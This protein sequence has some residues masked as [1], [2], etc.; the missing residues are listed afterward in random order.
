MGS[1]I[2]WVVMACLLAVGEMLTMGFF[3]A[4]FA[5]GAF[6][7][8]IVA[9]AGAGAAPA[10]ISFAAGTA[11][12]FAVVRPVAKRH[13]H[14]PPEIRTGT[15][16]L[17]GRP[18]IVIERVANHENLGSVKIDGEVWTARA[19]DE[20][21]VIAAGARVEVIEIRGATALVSE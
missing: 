14:T 20:D 18:A 6:V 19:Y 15:A 4:P 16:A 11:L 12:S 17:I 8:A 2:A 1:W 5:V 3:L 10:T 7:A 9:L 21:R 13:L